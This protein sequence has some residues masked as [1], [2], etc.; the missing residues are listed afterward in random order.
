MTTVAT[1][2]PTCPYCHVAAKLVDSIHGPVYICPNKDTCDARVGCHPGS[3]APLGGLANGELRKARIAAHAAFDRIWKAK[4]KR[5]RCRQHVARSAGY[6]WLAI[7]LNIAETECHI[8]MMN[9]ELC[10][11]VVTVCTWPRPL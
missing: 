7:Q 5:D 1:A 3:T 10:R 9:M 2:P 8:G 11:R 4:M 6:Q